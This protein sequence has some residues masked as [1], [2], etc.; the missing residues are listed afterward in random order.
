MVRPVK[1][2]NADSGSDYK[3]PENFKACN[4]DFFFKK[5]GHDYVVCIANDLK[6]EENCPIT[7]IAFEIDEADEELYEEPII[8]PIN[9]DDTISLYISRKIMQH[10]I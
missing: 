6:M 2:D 7:S 4:Q 8:R 1:D 10:G 5:D 9:D 3:C